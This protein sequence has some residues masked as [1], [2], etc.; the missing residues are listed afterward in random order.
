MAL[1]TLRQAD[2][3]MLQSIYNLMKELQ[4]ETRVESRRA[5]IATK[6]LQ[7]T[8]RKVV[9]S[10][11]E[12]EEKLNTMEQRMMVVEADVVALREQCES[13]GGQLTGIMWK[14][15]DQEN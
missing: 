6:R 12:I 15:Q 4:T 8:V 14:C 3:E 1:S 9:K 7:G 11:I 10:C 13:H 5:R 2:S